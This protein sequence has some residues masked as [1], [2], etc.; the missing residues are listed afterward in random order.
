MSP[1]GLSVHL[2][3]HPAFPFWYLKVERH[4]SDEKLC[5]KAADLAGTDD[6]SLGCWAYAVERKAGD[7]GQG[8]YWSLVWRLLRGAG[9]ESGNGSRQLQLIE[10][11]EHALPLGRVF[12][13]VDRRG[14]IGVEAQDIVAKRG[15]GEIELPRC[16]LG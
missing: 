2:C 1:V 13:C 16:Q 9:R 7:E 15:R 6:K 3:T 12:F 10:R 5:W 11:G 8:P 14:E 4:F